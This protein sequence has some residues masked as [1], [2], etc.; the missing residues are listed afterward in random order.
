MSQ[1]EPII[2]NAIIDK[3]VLTTDDHGLLSGW[4]FLTY[5]T[6][7]Q[8]FG[9]NA[10]YLPKSFRHHRVESVCGHW[11]WR[12]MEIAGV[13]EWDKLPGRTIR[14]KCTWSKVYAIGHIVKDDWFDPSRDFENLGKDAEEK[15]TEMK[16]RLED[17]QA[18]IESQDAL[19]ARADAAEALA[20]ENAKVA[21]QACADYRKVQKAAMAVIA[22]HAR[23]NLGGPG[24][25][26][27]IDDLRAALE[28]P[29]GQ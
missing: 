19:R 8:G 13:T 23:G 1:G 29:D 7:G 17:A 21:D 12:V 24:D 28:V 3:A 14:V 22:L 4:L 11:I 25:S 6:S 5:E 27:A 9:G 26:C 16:E 15:L 18:Q 20:A 10:L 2:Q